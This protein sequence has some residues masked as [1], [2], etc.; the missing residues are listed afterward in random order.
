[1]FELDDLLNAIEGDVFEEKPVEIEEFVT[2]KEYLGLM[3]LSEN[4]L[5]LVRASTQIY[6]KETLKMW[7]GDKKAEQRW[8]ETFNEIIFILGKGSGKDHCSVIS[9]AYI[10]YL[11]LCLKQ[12]AQYY[13]Y[14]EGN[15]F[16]IINVAVNA[17]QAKRVFFNNLVKTIKKSPWFEG[18]YQAKADGS[19][20]T[21]NELNFDKNINIY[22]GHSEREAFEGYNVF[23]VVLDEISAFAEDSMSTNERA[24]TAEAVYQMYSQSVTSRYPD[25]GKTVLLSWPRYK[26]DFI[27]T[28]YNKV[29]AEKD[30]IDRSYTFKLDEELPDGVPG[31]EFTIEWEEDHII[32]YE[33]DRVFALRRPSWEVNPTKKIQHY[34]KAFFEDP[35]DSLGRFA[36]QP[37]D[38]IAGFFR[39]HDKID[40]CFSAVNGVTE[41]GHFLSI[42]QPKE[43]ETEYF[44][45]VDLA[46]K[47][48]RCAV[49]IA[50]VD[51]WE[52]REFAGVPTELR[53]VVKV[54]A[55]RYWT[56][57]KDKTVDFPE[58]RE[59]I[60]NLR[61]RG[62]NI[63]RVTFDRWR[64][65]D[66]IDYLNGIG[67]KAEVLSVDIK[68]YTDLAMLVMERRVEGPKIDIL[69]TELKQLRIMNNGKIDHP[70][71]GSKDL[72]DATC[73]AVYN[74]VTYADS[75]REI[76][77]DVKTSDDLRAEAA[78]RREME[79]RMAE[80]T[81]VIKP[82]KRTAPDM[83]AELVDFLD[84]WT[85][86]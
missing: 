13:G 36:C 62:F 22:S 38:A 86:L 11:L 54:D 71:T 24:N 2:S 49:A 84:S 52:R 57:T 43:D 85:A 76:E 45:H 59:Y 10:V 74:C 26:G 18:R 31:N 75:M 1:M 73:G 16:D 32:R 21:Q 41:E 3:P 65:D 64:S 14:D 46:K 50:H 70:R 56:P 47:H 40:E 42:F 30:V 61:R 69:L 25:F 48:D 4:Q 39:D 58:V 19:P 67:I 82:P 33:V 7:L 55:V 53:P 60:V 5:K 6:R 72:A 20:T 51:R 28:R 8:K 35:L 15:S 9:C 27:S 79:A 78:A 81:N 83:P 68:H 12:P 44:I 17:D 29:I 63:R 66:M 34:K 23:F 80:S 77:I 37:P